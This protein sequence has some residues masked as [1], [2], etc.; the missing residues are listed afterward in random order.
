MST[1]HDDGLFFPSRSP[2][3]VYGS[4]QWEKD[5]QREIASRPAVLPLNQ[6]KSFTSTELAEISRHVATGM[7]RDKAVKL[8]VDSRQ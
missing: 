1:L 8:V 7:A 3:A 5:N 2:H 6:R 4:E